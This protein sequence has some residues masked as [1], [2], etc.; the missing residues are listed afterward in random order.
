MVKFKYSANATEVW[1][2]LWRVMKLLQNH[3]RWQGPRGLALPEFCRI[4]NNRGSGGTACSWCG[5]LGWQRLAVAALYLI[6]PKNVWRFRHIFVNKGTLLEHVINYR[7]LLEHSWVDILYL[8]T[9]GWTWIS[10]Q[11]YTHFLNQK[12]KD[13]KCWKQPFSRTSRSKDAVVQK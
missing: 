5:H 7:F 10:T 13:T 12:S 3:H 8:S 11:G 6:L 1:L 2:N 9:Y 4:K